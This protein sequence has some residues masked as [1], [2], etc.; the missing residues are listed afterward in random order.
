LTSTGPIDGFVLKLDPTGGVQWAHQFAKVGNFGPDVYDRLGTRA[1]KGIALDYSNASGN[2]VASVVVTGY[3]FGHV[4]MDPVA[5]PGLHVLDTSGLENDNGSAYVVKLD[6]AGNFLWER[7]RTARAA[8]PGSPSPW[9]QNI[10]S[11]PPVN[12]GITPGS[13]TA[14]SIT[15]TRL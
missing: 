4:D 13:T 2:V 8:P 9:T 1:P 3:F 10:M 11:I 6:A 14:Q 5:H 7:N 12:L 15:T